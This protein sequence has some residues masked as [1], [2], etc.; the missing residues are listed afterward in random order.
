MTKHGYIKLKDIQE[1]F[2]VISFKVHLKII[3][4]MN[5]EGRLFKL[6]NKGFLKMK[7]LTNVILGKLFNM[8]KQLVSN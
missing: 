2:L 6:Y 4:I 8:F 7:T 5:Q 3:K 1:I